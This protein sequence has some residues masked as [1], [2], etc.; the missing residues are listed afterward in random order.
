MAKLETVIERRQ[1]V[2]DAH[3]SEVRQ[4]LLQAAEKLFGTRS[5]EQTKISEIAAEAKIATG[6]V[7]R[8]FPSKQ[9]LLVELLSDLN[10]QLRAAML[11]TIGDATSQR[12]IERAGFSAF[13]DFLGRHPHLFRIQREAEFVAPAAYRE[14]FEE[15]ARRYARGAKDAM[16]RGEVDSRFDPEFLGYIYLGIAHFIGARW[17]EWTGTTIPAD[18]AE[19][20][21][22]LLEKALRPDTP[23]AQD[24]TP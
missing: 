19:Q 18:I 4:R 3:A 22:L 2:P 17:I 7:Y 6:S 12:E 11:E 13:F 5:F 20:T 8:Y 1:R 21:F 9:A 23:A 15:L 24:G 16:L 10:G 14:Y